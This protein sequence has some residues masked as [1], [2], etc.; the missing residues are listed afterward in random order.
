[1]AYACN[2]RPL[3]PCRQR[4]V[5]QRL[6]GGLPIAA[7]VDDP[8]PADG[9]KKCKPAAG[10]AFQLFILVP[11]R[12]ID[13]DVHRETIRPAYA[14]KGLQVQR[15]WQFRP[16]L[17]PPHQARPVRNRHF[18]NNQ[19]A[20]RLAYFSVTPRH[21]GRW[22][23]SPHADT[24]TKMRLFPF[25]NCPTPHSSPPAQCPFLPHPL[26]TCMAAAKKIL[27]FFLHMVRC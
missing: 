15:W 8:R 23:K 1:M 26:Y 16:R 13:L 3:S 12:R 20:N 22:A 27:I 17:I 4:N 9:S 24:E 19:G 7:Q 6:N 10:A 25:P 5:F 2:A 14:V 18:V 21:Q 11:P